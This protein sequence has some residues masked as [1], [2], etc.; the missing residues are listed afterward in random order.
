MDMNTIMHVGMI[1]ARLRNFMV[2]KDT[3]LSVTVDYNPDKETLCFE[4]S[5][6]FGL[7]L[8]FPSN[9]INENGDYMTDQEKQD[10]VAVL[11]EIADEY[12]SQLQ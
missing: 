5:A 9:A 8:N 6:G 12:N 10:L 3:N 2:D 1:K 4:N 7:Q 11:T